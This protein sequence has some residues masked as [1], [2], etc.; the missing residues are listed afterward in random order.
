MIETAHPE[1]P[2]LLGYLLAADEAAAIR[3]GHHLIETGVSPQDVLL[4]LIAPV[5]AH[6]GEL[7]ARNRLTVA[8]EHV[9]S[10]L[11][12]RMTTVCAGARRPAQRPERL[13]VVCADGEWHTLPSRLVTEVLRMHGFDVTFLGASVPA[14]HLTTYL[15]QHE[16][17]AV[18]LSISVPTRLPAARRSVLAARAAGVPVLA[19]GLGFGGTGRWAYRIGVD[20]WAA[21]AVEAAA[22]F[23]NWPP[24][25]AHGEHPADD[26]YA[27]LIKEIPGLVVS[28][29]DVLERRFGP[30]PG[31][32]ARQREAT[33]EDLN[34]L[35][36][37][38]AAALYVDDEELFSDFIEWM[39]TV[40]TARQVP[41]HGVDLIVEHWQESLDDRKRTARMLAAGRTALAA[42]L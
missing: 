13:V 9:A 27:Q 14:G 39:T 40:L 6:I 19:G 17:A 10:Y 41:A 2:T 1:C 3:L 31:Y 32:S 24:Q 34:H 30:M 18:L 7:W 33:A 5:Q 35:A 25:R 36:N 37:F 20:A 22:V 11:C 21:D 12:D 42:R 16:P 8:D 4:R 28:S 15:Q 26:E 23:A 29:L 38:L